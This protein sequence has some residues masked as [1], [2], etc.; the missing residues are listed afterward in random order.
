MQIQVNTDRHIE[1]SA[2]LTRR[3]EAV[4]EG[5]LGRFGDRVTRVEVHLSDTNSS[6]KSGDA[7]KRCVMEAR[8]AGLKP[9][10]VS[11]DGA[12][13]EQVL[14]GAADKLEKTLRRAL[15]R[16]DDPKGRTSFAGDQ[17]P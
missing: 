6:Q 10:A 9:I 2:E 3:V 17:S 7:D 13:L 1:G 15:G 4:V 8:V 14:D 11:D 16:L 12:S 5:A